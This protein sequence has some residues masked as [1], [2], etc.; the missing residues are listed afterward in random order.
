M[1]R[2]NAPAGG[3]LEPLLA[4]EGGRAAPLDAQRVA[5][6]AKGWPMA[7]SASAAVIA[8]LAVAAWQLGLAWPPRG[9]CAAHFTSDCRGLACAAAALLILL[10]WLAVEAWCRP[11]KDGSPED[12]AGFVSTYC[13]WWVTP[14]LKK[15]NA[16]GKL[17]SHDLPELPAQ[18]RAAHLKQKFRETWLDVSKRR[19]LLVTLLHGIQ[20]R[21]LLM[22]LLH[23]WAFLGLMF[24]DPIILKKLLDT[25][26]DASATRRNVG[27]ACFLAFSMFLRVSFMEVC[28]FGSVRV[29]NNART[30]VAP[31]VFARALRHST[32]LDSGALTN[33]MATD[34][35][36]LGRWTWTVFFL[37]QWSFAVV[38]LPAVVYCMYSLLGNAAFCGAATLLITNHLSMV[39]A[40]RTK[41]VVSKLQEARDTRASLVSEAVASIRLLK[42]R[43]WA[44]QVKEDISVSR[45]AE[46]RH[47]VTIRYLDAANVLL[48]ALS[49]LAVPASIFSYYTVVGRHTLTPAVAF[50]ALAWVQQMRWS[51]NTL[52][53]IYN[54]WAALQ[55]SC[56]RLGAFLAS[57]VHVRAEDASCVCS[58]KGSV[59]HDGVAVLKIDVDA[60]PGDVVVITGP[61]G[62]GKSTLLATLA[63]ALPPLSGIVQSSS[64]RAYVAQRPFLSE[65][66]VEENVVFGLPL[67]EDRLREAIKRAQL[68][69]D[70]AALPGGLRAEVGPAGVQLSGGQRAR[71]ALARALYAR[72]S[73]CVLDDV[74]SAVDAHTGARIWEE[75]VCYLARQDCCV[76]L[77]THQL[78]YA[79]R[80]EVSRVI[81]LGACADGQTEA[82]VT[83][84]KF[85]VEEVE[86]VPPSLKDVERELRR[87]LQDRHGHVVDAG[88]VEDVLS[89][90]RGRP[91]G[92]QRREGLLA[93]RDVRLYL[94]AFGKQGKV[95]LLLVLALSGCAL[96]VAANIWL[97]VWADSGGSRRTQ[98]RRLLTYVGIGAA[99]AVVLAIQTVVLTLCALDASRT[100]HSQMLEAVMSAPM[101]FFDATPIGHVLNR[102]LQD[103]ANVDMDVP[104][105]TLDQLTRTLSVASQ[106]GLVLFFAP[107]VALSLPLILIPYVFIFRTVRVAAR[108]ARRLEAE[109]HG[110]CYAHFHDCI[111]GRGTILAFGAVARFEMENERLTDDMAR[112]RYANEAVCKWSQALTTQNGC[113]LYLAAGLLGVYLVAHGRMT[114]G[115]LGLIL[116][117]SASLQRAAMEY[118][119]GL[120]TLEAQFVSVERVAQYCRLRKE[121]TDGRDVAA[122]TRP[123]AVQV[124]KLMLRYH[125][126]RPLALKSVSF[127]VEAGQK[128][129]ICG[130]TGSGKSSLVQCLARLYDYSGVICVDGLDLALLSLPSARSLVRVVQQDATLKTGSLRRNLI[131][132][133]RV[134]DATIW[135]ALR[136]VGA[137]ECVIRCGGL[138]FEVGEGGAAFSAGERQLLALTRALLPTP[139]RLLLADECSSNVDEVS[140]RKVHDVLL[141]LDATVLAICHRLKHVPRFDA[142]VVLDRGRV[143]ESG[144]SA[145]LLA[146][147]SSRLAGLVGRQSPSSG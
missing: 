65:G 20:P 87:A 36:K 75:A 116:L 11:P 23:G 53:D 98:I 121:R 73:L 92:E 101:A 3:L 112:G 24:L 48:G 132:P 139:P 57:D 145:S 19:S 27:Y 136:L 89:T 128:V 133:A 96:G 118:M 38:S 74:L 123:C 86:D 94:D 47:L 2:D 147:A 80:P 113:V 21:V 41:P 17:A 126:D 39:L 8:Y 55:P 88:F 15:A 119:T 54:L 66:T 59:G 102:F 77:A 58:F 44:L 135:A 127:V 117:Y 14:I 70:L 124:Q 60:G 99:E 120:A 10:V 144:A 141:G 45:K 51:I 108:D 9:A 107:W 37:A 115:Q 25:A 31:A 106:L 103:L 122:S 78:H 104:T 129:A 6:A 79:R 72:P 84:S 22:T 131:G 67:N 34:A 18:D 1:P 138:D 111:R 81:S 26:D 56:E 30:A 93:W 71:V 16:Q 85:A 140:D 33:L 46:M 125:L 69:Q 32:H 12:R 42:L 13:F 43:G 40:R 83:P 29:M 5:P 64:Q 49:G 91:E 68:T 52:P 100:L 82:A 134:D 61:V 95:A 143:V 146:D 63:R 76:V 35:D 130:R 110:P 4:A 90:L 97:S 114:T 28:F 142:V 62:S 109:A 105:T 137:A 7:R 50:A